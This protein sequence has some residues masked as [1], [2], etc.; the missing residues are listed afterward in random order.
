M[1]LWKEMW[2]FLVNLS[3]EWLPQC[4]TVN[5]YYYFEVLRKPR[6]KNS[7]REVRN[8]EKEL[9]DPSRQSA[10]SQVIVMEQPPYW[11]DIEG[12]NGKL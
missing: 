5:Q 4:Q 7:Q 12:K 10:G 8:M 3:M 2:P 6:E 9:I 11:P 1:L